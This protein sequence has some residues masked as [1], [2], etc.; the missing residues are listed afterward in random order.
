MN[1]RNCFVI[2]QNREESQYNDFIGKFYHFPKKYIKQL[3]QDNI[4]F[5]YYEP[6][7]KGEGRYCRE[8]DQGVDRFAG[9]GAF[10]RLPT[11]YGYAGR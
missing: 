8:E 7:K 11:G 4:E 3:S 9:T 2:L 5:V 6:K 1:K 10:E